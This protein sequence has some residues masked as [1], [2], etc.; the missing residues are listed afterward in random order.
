MSKPKNMKISTKIRM[1][2]ILICAF[3]LISMS[4]SAY[5]AVKEI[6]S[7]SLASNTAIGDS[8]RVDAESAVLDHT[9]HFLQVIANEQAKSC[10]NVLREIQHKVLLFEGAMRDIFNNPEHYQQSRAIINQGNVTPGT[11]SNTWL[12]PASV[13]ITPEIEKE[14]VMMSNLEMIMPALIA[15][16]SL[17][18]AYAVL[19]N[20]LMYSYTPLRFNDPQ[21][22]SRIR[23]WY[24]QAKM[25]PQKTIFT[26][27]YEDATGKGLIITAA[28]NLSDT[29]GTFLGVVALDVQL[30]ALT[31][32]I[33]ETQITKSGYAFIVDNAGRYVVHPDMGKEGFKEYL[34]HDDKMAFND[35]Y[36]RILNREKGFI[37]GEINGEAYYLTFSPISLTDWSVGVIMSK[38]EALASLKTFTKQMELLIVDSQ[39]NALNIS[40]NTI[41]IFSGIFFIVAVMVIML[42]VGI[43]YF[44]T[45][46]IT[47]L[48]YEIGKINENNLQHKIPIKSNDEIGVLTETFNRMTKSLHEYTLNIL[49]LNLTKAQ[50]ETVAYTDA[51]TNIFNR[52]YFMT[53][54]ALHLERVLKSRTA[55]YIILF[56]IDHFK[57]VNDTYGHP[58]GDETLKSIAV[59]VKE[60]IRPDDIFARYGGEEFI[61]FVSGVDKTIICALAER[62][63][64]SISKTPIIFEDV[65]FTV[66]ASF[67]IASAAPKND[68]HTAIK[69]ADEALYCAKNAGRD[70]VMFWPAEAASALLEGE[71]AGT[72]DA[73]RKS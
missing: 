55:A 36:K 49:E 17:V 70:N 66:T 29:A 12:L 47:N 31:K 60:A 7:Y 9:R 62:I 44:L 6:I 20:G 65:H 34:L 13:Q 2:V 10:D 64:R 42:A 59:R 52:R 30:D 15:H 45:E 1:Y 3:A 8:A 32:I 23:P 56:D 46:P 35:A 50:L 16:A 4:I 67:G 24:L 22:D 61:I 28:K 5:I 51:L 43:S 21:Y 18:E 48:I 11:Y 14:I 69:L 41:L 26:D 37:E 27:V 73:L 71:N 57:R 25:F 58:A 72:R 53:V 54:A 39:K 63:R 40:E 19:A 68:L 33:L 38:D